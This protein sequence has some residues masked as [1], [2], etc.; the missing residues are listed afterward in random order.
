[1]G[2][3]EWGEIAL[4]AIRHSP[5]TAQMPRSPTASLTPPLSLIG[6][7]EHVRLPELGLGPVVAKVDTG[8]L[9][10]A[11]HAEAIAVHGKRVRFSVRL[12]DRLHDCEARLQGSKTIRSSTGHSQNRLVIETELIVGHQAFS[13][14][15][16]L[17][18]RTD[19]G[20]PM[21]L[22]RAAIRGRFMV[23]PGRTFILDAKVRRH[24]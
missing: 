17:A 1:M 4:F 5:F 23:H 6:W 24:K 7:R 15:V 18:D 2:S 22:G 9:W 3:G 13:A 12:G 19:M 20:V 21:L 10:C 16:T 11:L 14:E 8:A